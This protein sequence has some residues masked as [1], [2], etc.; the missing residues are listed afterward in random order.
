MRF[1]AGFLQL[2]LLYPRPE[3]SRLMRQRLCGRKV[4]WV[5]ATHAE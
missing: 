1:R 2:R 4:Q 3:L 5:S